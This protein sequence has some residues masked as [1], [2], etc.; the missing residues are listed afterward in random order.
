MEQPPPAGFQPADEVHLVR[1]ACKIVA[2]ERAGWEARAPGKPPQF[3]FGFFG[4]P[5]SGFDP[6][7]N[8]EWTF[9]VTSAWAE[10]MS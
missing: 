3:P 4:V 2:L 6:G 8:S 5:T 10:V 9:P 7:T 1:P